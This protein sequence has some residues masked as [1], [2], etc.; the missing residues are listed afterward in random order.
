MFSRK[1][2]T[3]TFNYWAKSTGDNTIRGVIFIFDKSR[4]KYGL[5]VRYGQ[6]S[7]HSL[8]G[9]WISRWLNQEVDVG[10]RFLGMDV[11]IEFDA[12]IIFID[13]C[14]SHVIYGNFV[15][16]VHICYY[17]RLVNWFQLISL[18]QLLIFGCYNLFSL[19]SFRLYVY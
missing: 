1:K 10:F 4:T 18:C 11:G 19:G 15:S 12:V 16:F 6:S 8:D 3:E 9:V 13:F 14:N 17:G 2:E 5:N 7:M